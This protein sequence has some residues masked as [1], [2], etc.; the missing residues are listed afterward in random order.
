MLIGTGGGL[1]GFP[2]IGGL[3]VSGI[4]GIVTVYFGLTRL[5]HSVFVG[6]LEHAW[7]HET[8]VYNHLTTRPLE[9]DPTA[10]FLSA[11][12]YLMFKTNL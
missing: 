1:A 8:L 2:R 4:R 12:N 9:Y 6:T 7:L 11:I 3:V 5:R 10:N